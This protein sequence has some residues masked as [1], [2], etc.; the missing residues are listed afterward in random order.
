M[1]AV[2]VINGSDTRAIEALMAGPVVRN[3]VV[4]ARDL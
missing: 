3:G 1:P 4:A 2:E